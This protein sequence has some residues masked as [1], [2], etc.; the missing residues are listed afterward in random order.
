MPEALKLLRVADIA[1]HDTT[2]HDILEDNQSRVAKGNRELDEANC[3]S[4]GSKAVT[5][6]GSSKKDLPHEI[7]A[8]L[9]K[10]NTLNES[11]QVPLTEGESNDTLVK[12]VGSFLLIFLI[13]G[14]ACIEFLFYKVVKSHYIPVSQ[15]KGQKNKSNEGSKSHSQNSCATPGEF[16]MVF[17]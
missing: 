7:L 13:G 17:C 11:C 16:E 9:K 15:V 14:E 3:G 12:E 4:H 8:I 2:K 1:Q 5:G 10:E 6:K